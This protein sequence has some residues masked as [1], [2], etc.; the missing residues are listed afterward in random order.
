MPLHEVESD[1]E[2]SAAIASI[3]SGPTSPDHVIRLK[4]GVDFGQLFDQVQFPDYVTIESET[5]LGAFVEGFMDDAKFVR[6]VG[7]KFRRINSDRIERIIVDGCQLDAAATTHTALFNEG[8][9]IEI[10][11]S[12]L[13][14]GRDDIVRLINCQDW[15]IDHCTLHDC[16]PSDPD[17]HPDI[18]QVGDWISGGQRVERGR[19]SNCL[20][21]DDIATGA[22]LAQGF[23][24]KCHG[25]KDII[26]DNLLVRSQLSNGINYEN[27]SSTDPFER[28]QI[29]N[30][31]MIGRNVILE[32]LQ[33]G[34]KV[35]NVVAAAITFAATFN[36]PT[37]TSTNINNFAH[38]DQNLDQL[39]TNPAG[40]GVWQ[41]YVPVDDPA[42]PILD[43][44]ATA[45]INEL[46]SGG[47]P[48]MSFT[49]TVE[50][51]VDAAICTLTL[52]ADGTGQVDPVNNVT[53]STSFQYRKT[54][55]IFGNHAIGTVNVN[56][57]PP[58]VLA[59]DGALQVDA[60]T[61]LPFDLN[62]L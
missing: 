3:L 49:F 31:S 10:L 32:G 25:A 4:D 28:C 1:T 46:E 43:N 9:F 56:V 7:V 34:T 30:I 2:L 19:V 21:Y 58:T 36:D 61:P 52:N 15:V 39:F 53:G 35:E 29:T 60:N 12:E 45:Y 48:T 62:T 47:N 51:D 37:G 20:L 50:T 59:P 23:F 13:M 24:V 6:F 27:M 44:G 40:G 14:N 41:D 18:I 17:A 22:E 55:D 11:N 8:N 33:H 57:V 54:S 16:V 5:P 42:N 38:N 26:A